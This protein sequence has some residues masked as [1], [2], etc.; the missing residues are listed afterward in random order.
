MRSRGVHQALCISMLLSCA[1]LA[2]PPC[3]AQASDGSGYFRKA[4]F[5]LGVVYK[6]LSG[7]GAYEEYVEESDS[8][9][10]LPSDGRTL[11]GLS[12]GG[13][14][15]AQRTSLQFEF[16][17]SGDQFLYQEQRALIGGG[18]T[19]TFVSIHYTTIGFRLRQAFFTRRLMI[20][21]GF[22]W[23]EEERIRESDDVKTQSFPADEFPMWSVGVDLRINRGLLVGFVHE[24][25]FD[26]QVEETS[27]EIEGWTASALHLT[28]LL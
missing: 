2:P 6:R 20:N 11:W 22:A 16:A 28:L 4:G 7:S 17:R 5:T 26:H 24:W 14:L 10:M 15:W 13:Y 21:G 8:Y 18:V 9:R 27:L 25:S 23:I 1:A 12:V 19:D 3:A